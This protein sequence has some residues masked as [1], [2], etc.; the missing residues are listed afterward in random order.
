MQELSGVVVIEDGKLLLLKRKKHGHFEL[1]GG[2]IEP[3]ETKEAAAVREAKEEIGCDVELIQYMGHTLFQIKGKT[4]KSHKFLASI[5][6]GQTPRIAEQDVFSEL[7]WM[8]LQEY[9]KHPVAPNVKTFC[10]SFLMG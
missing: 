9:T 8:P 10:E 5:A 2:R 4:F 7:M 6:P 3:G 1:P